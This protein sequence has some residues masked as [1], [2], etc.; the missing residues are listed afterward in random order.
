MPKDLEKIEKTPQNMCYEWKNVIGKK[1]E[2]H[3]CEG[4]L[5]PC[6]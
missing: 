5:T 6:L 3:Q 2:C 4:T 1:V